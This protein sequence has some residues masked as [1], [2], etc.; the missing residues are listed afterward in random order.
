LLSPELERSR[1]S[2]SFALGDALPPVF[3]DRM[4]IQQVLINL[5]T[6]AIRSLR[7]TRG[8]L[9]RIDIRSASPDGANVLLDV[10]DNGTGIPAGTME[11]IFDVFFTTRPHGT[12]IGLSLCR[13]IVEKHGGNLWA[14]QGEQHGATFH[15]QLHAADDLRHAVPKE[16]G[17]PA[18]LSAV[19]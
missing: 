14:S 19:R 2:L 18:G 1:I 3:A 13:T 7:A 15:M 11:H 5:F 6:N 12:G 17:K 9:R 4:Q 8:R 10:S 16:T